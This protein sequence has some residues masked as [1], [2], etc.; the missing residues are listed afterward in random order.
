MI[1]CTTLGDT[2]KLVFFLPL[3]ALTPQVQLCSVLPGSEGLQLVVGQMKHPELSMSHQQ[4]DT[5]VRQAV[6]GHIEL[7]QPAE[8]VL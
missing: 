7:L 6:I 5:L 1:K 2:H 3:A 4:R 8:A